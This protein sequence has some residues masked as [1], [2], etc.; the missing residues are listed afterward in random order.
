MRFQ[1]YLYIALSIAVITSS[2][3][4]QDTLAGYVQGFT[5][6]ESGV[7]EVSGLIVATSSA[8]EDSTGIKGLIRISGGE[9][10]AI[11]SGVF[12]SSCSQSGNVPYTEGA[13]S[14]QVTFPLITVASTANYSTFSVQVNITGVDLVGLAPTNISDI[15]IVDENN[16]L[17]ACGA[18]VP[19]TGDAAYA[20][21]IS[22]ISAGT[23]G[24]SSYVGFFEYA[25]AL[26]G[27][28]FAA[29]T[30]PSTAY[31]ANGAIITENCAQVTVKILN[32]TT[33]TFQLSRNT[34]DAVFIGQG[35]ES[36]SIIPLSPS[37]LALV[38]F[39]PNN[40]SPVLGTCQDLLIAPTIA[41]TTTTSAPGTTGGSGSGSSSGSSNSTA[42]TTSKNG[43]VATSFYGLVSLVALTT[44]FF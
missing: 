5:A 44:L 27:S 28:V 22:V 24:V 15:A 39:E 9:N 4:A 1:L 7:S 38:V 41:N 8:T 40:G 18:I 13:Q 17:I 14:A 35:A 2:V 29:V 19:G 30:Y 25:S 23:S 11:Y 31:S 32:A 3:H 33:D 21:F 10:G 34:L 42:T 37:A 20:S 36:D 26:S 6:I 16:T 43:A 12:A